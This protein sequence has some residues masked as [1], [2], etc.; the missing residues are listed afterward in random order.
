MSSTLFNPN[1]FSGLGWDYKRYY[2]WNTGK[3]RSLSGKR[4][5]IDYM[6]YPL[7]HYEWMYNILHDD[8]SPSELQAVMGL[9]NSVAGQY[10]TFLM[11]DPDFNTISA[12]NATKFG[13]SDGTTTTA[14]QLTALYAP[15][16]GSFAGIGASEI[17][18]NLNGVP[19][20]YDQTNATVILSSHY[21]I[22]PT[23]L[24]TF[25]T[26]TTSGHA[27]LWS[28][29]WFYRVSFEDDSLDPTEFMHQ[30]WDLK[31]KVMSIIL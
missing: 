30:W 1:T 25:T 14:Y 23:G 15:T 18:Q 11:T 6:I 12:A 2:E 5:T 9:F 26:P 21:T 19:V 7:V 4:S 8:V 3:Q 10:D 22:G 24:V 27:I 17:I 13:T 20:L 16:S 29:S 31:L 28:G